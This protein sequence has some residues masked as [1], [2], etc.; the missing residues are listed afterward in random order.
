LGG[1]ETAVSE[2]SENISRNEPLEGLWIQLDCQGCWE[3]KEKCQA[4]RLLHVQRYSVRSLGGGETA[5]SEVFENISRNE[6]LDGLWIQLDCQGYWENKE[7]CQARRL[8]HVQRYSV[9]SSHH[10]CH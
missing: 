1:G 8:L 5:V 6:P 3:N 7:N 10:Q 2:V 4:C 9:R